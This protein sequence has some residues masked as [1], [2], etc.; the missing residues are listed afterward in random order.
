MSTPGKKKKSDG[1]K[2]GAK[3][4]MITEKHMSR[5]TLD[6]P[7]ESEIVTLLK[8]D[9]NSLKE[10]YKLSQQQILTERQSFDDEIY[11]SK[12]EI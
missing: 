8:Y 12:V 11:S 1:K 2:V 10:K 7:E 4:E 9:I 3:R 6:V 5:K